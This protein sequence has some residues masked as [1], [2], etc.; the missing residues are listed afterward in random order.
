MRED[1]DDREKREGRHGAWLVRLTPY[2]CSENDIKSN[3]G[4]CCFI[5]NIDLISYNHDLMVTS[6]IT[7]D[8]ARARPCCS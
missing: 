6:L 2:L 1:A 8:N 5:L 7:L 3:N 4:C